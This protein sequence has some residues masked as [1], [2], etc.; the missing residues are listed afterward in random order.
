MMAPNFQSSRAEKSAVTPDPPTPNRA[1]TAAER[2]L[3]RLDAT[4]AAE[5]RGLEPADFDQVARAAEHRLDADERPL[6]EERVARN[7][8]LALRAADLGRF[9]AEAYPESARVLAFPSLVRHAA[10]PW[11][12]WAAAAAAV[13]LAVLLRSSAPTLA[14]E[15]LQAGPTSE[16][17]SSTPGETLFSDG[18]ENGD[19]SSWTAVSSSG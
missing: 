13:L 15:E 3:A 4:L 10:A 1:E 5:E 8:E 9:R 19:P 6:W 2:W 17:S 11:L 12:G 7:P 16:P 18:F 14:P